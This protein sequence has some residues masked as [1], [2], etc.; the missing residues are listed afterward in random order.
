MY[1]MK[2]RQ[3]RK[4]LH[5]ESVLLRS[6]GI[7]MGLFIAGTGAAS[8]Q[9]SADPIQLIQQQYAD[10]NISEAM[11]RCDAFMKRNPSNA[12][13]HYLKGNC[14]VKLNRL[15]EAAGEYDYAEKLAP[16]SAVA[17][18]C[19]TAA[20]SIAAMNAKPVA[21]RKA[22]PD[23]V[24]SEEDSES[25]TSEGAEHREAPAAAG[26][27]KV[28]ANTLETIRKQAVLARK[29][30]LDMGKAEA[31]G[32]RS[33]SENAANSMREKAERSLAQPRG[34]TEAVSVS[35]EEAAAMRARASADGDRLRAIGKWRASVA[36]MESR[37]KADE[38][39]QQAQNLQERLLDEKKSPY[40][41]VKLNPVGTNLY[42]R[43]YAKPAERPMRVRSTMV[44]LDSALTAAELKEKYKREL[45]VNGVASKARS[46]V[47]DKTTELFSGAKGTTSS[48]K[49]ELL[50]KANDR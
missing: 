29:R 25:E 16:D 12:V 23:K 47:K 22:N 42:I 40:T 37:E 10:G 7:S 39:D 24:S 49:G 4:T 38:I 9:S 15:T 17:S 35:P 30:A 19:R 27:S 31:D 14:L 1:T 11:L 13:A 5:L 34:S 50:P 33:W 20:K 46:G 28:P 2:M 44:T 32:E 6:I 36:E 45:S 21:K 26:S 3:L 18:Y 43:N 48:V 41:S 8:A